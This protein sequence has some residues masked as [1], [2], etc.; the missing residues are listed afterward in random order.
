MTD[1]GTIGAALGAVALAVS[2]VA[3]ALGALALARGAPAR[4]ERVA[5]GAL[6]QATT[7]AEHVDSF[8]VE[9]GTV[10][11]SIE[12]EREEVRRQRRR[13]SSSESKGEERNGPPDGMPDPQD[14]EAY[15]AWLMATRAPGGIAAMGR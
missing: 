12:V 4:L 7:A 9:I 8:R 13:L 2:V 14:R 5:D 11:E 10:L 15:A 6:R 1:A 3:L